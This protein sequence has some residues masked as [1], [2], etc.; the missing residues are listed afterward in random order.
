MTIEMNY[1]IKTNKGTLENTKAVEVKNTPEG[2]KFLHEP[3]SYLD[4]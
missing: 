4:G 1:Q 3:Y 2:W